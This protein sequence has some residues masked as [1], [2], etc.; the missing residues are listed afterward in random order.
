MNILDNRSQLEHL[1]MVRGYNAREPVTK[2]SAYIVIQKIKAKTRD[3]QKYLCDEL[4]VRYKRDGIATLNR[5]TNYLERL[6]DQEIVDMEELIEKTSII[7][8]IIGTLKLNKFKRP[9]PTLK[10]PKV[11]ESIELDGKTITSFAELL[12]M[13]EMKQTYLYAPCVSRESRK[14]GLVSF[15]Y[16]SNRH[17]DKEFTLFRFLNLRGYKQLLIEK[18]LYP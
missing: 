9:A 17:I 15:G 11:F 8:V 13:L 6:E 2:V 18:H 14:R 1:K 4:H 5:F 12:V 10:I 16:D 3:S 7:E